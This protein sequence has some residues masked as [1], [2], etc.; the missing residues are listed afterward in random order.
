VTNNNTHAMGTLPNDN[1]RFL[2]SI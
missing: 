1:I 2:E